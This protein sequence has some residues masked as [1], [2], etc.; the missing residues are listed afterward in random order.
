[1]FLCKQ[2]NILFR[3]NRSQTCLILHSLLTITLG[4][5]FSTTTQAED[6]KSW[7]IASPYILP[8]EVTT[9]DVTCNNS[10]LIIQAEVTGQIF[11]VGC[12][13]VIGENSLLHQ[14]LTFSG[15]DITVESNADIFGDITQIGGRLQLSD[16]AN[17]H[18]MIHRY[19][20][21][22]EPPQRFL[23]ISQHYLTFQRI[24]PNNL[25]HLSRIAQELR[26]HRIIE[27]GRSPLE[28]FKVPNFLEF[29]FQKEQIR[30]AQK[31]IYEKNHYPIELQIMQFSSQEHS[32]QFWKNISTFTNLSMEHS[33]QNNLGDGGH[34]FFRF[35]NYSILTWHR[36]NWIFCAQVYA[37][38]NSDGI[39]NWKD[40]ETELDEMIRIFQQALVSNTSNPD[41]G[42]RFIGA[43]SISDIR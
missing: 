39:V 8:E 20:N 32:F 30:F 29:L 34:W 36:N 33:V 16:Q 1:M 24:V 26:L 37:Q 13:L 4:C 40:A 28:S 6:L 23:D 19:Q 27:K 35:Q 11:A 12:D 31:W 5:L 18:G 10:S 14:G 25:E 21:S 7:Q 15:G 17:L 22:I 38:T 2:T 42:D 3:Y 43:F 41:V 9:Q